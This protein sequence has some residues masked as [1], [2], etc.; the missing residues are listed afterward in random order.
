MSDKLNYQFETLD[1]KV[2]GVN[3]ELDKLIDQVNQVEK[4]VLVL[5]ALLE[6]VKALQGVVDTLNNQVNLVE[7]NLLVL[8]GEASVVEQAVDSITSNTGWL[9]KII[10]AGFVTAIIGWVVAGGLVV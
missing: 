5:C 8:K 9:Y 6:K 2:K 3:K 1:E 4:N 10:T 7:K